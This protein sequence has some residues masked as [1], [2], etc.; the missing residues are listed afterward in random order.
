MQSTSSGA[1]QAQH[2]AQ[3]SRNRTPPGGG[4]SGATSAPPRAVFQV[5]GP[6]IHC[7]GAAPEDGRRVMKTYCRIGLVV[8]LAAAAFT[9]SYA[10][11]QSRPAL[12]LS[13]IHI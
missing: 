4:G 10:S 5:V 9:F 8:V 7:R 1:L 12:G 13:L 11:A 6:R 3:A 2:S